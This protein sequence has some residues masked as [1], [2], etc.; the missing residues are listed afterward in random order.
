MADAVGGSFRDPSGCVLRHDGVL[1]RVIRASY[2]AD[3][4]R[5]AETGFIDELQREGQLIPHAAAERSLV[6]APDAWMVIRPETVPFIS[7]PWEWCFG[8]LKAAALLT[9]Q[10][11]RRALDRGFTLKDAGAT[12]IQ[13]IRS[14]P[15]LIDT[16]SFRRYEEGSPWIAY[17]QFCQHFLA[18]LLLMSMVDPR[19]ALIGRSHLDGIPLDLAATLLPARTR[20]RPATA[21][22]IHL[23]ASS[24]RKHADDRKPDPRLAHRVSRTGLLGLIDNLE[25][26][27]RGLDCRLTGGAWWDYEETHA[28][29]DGAREAKDRLVLQLA[30]S[31]PGVVWDLGANSGRYAELVSSAATHVV[32]MDLDH[33]AVERHW[34]RRVQNPRPILP[35]V[36]DLTNPSPSAGWALQERESLATRG[37]AD[38]LLALALVHHLAIGNNIPMPMIVTWLATIGRRVLIE[39]IP[40]EDSQIQR[41]LMAREDIF[42]D[43]HQAAFE[44]AF[45]ERFRMVAREPVAG[46]GRVMYCFEKA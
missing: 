3:W 1:H 5:L 19:L 28:Y 42:P 34:R 36:M 16:L 4:E 24:I 29:S 46:T 22:H 9:L 14:Q 39:W 20:W 33:G 38:T 6:S 17:R 13:F 30:G 15:V 7:Y 10:L 43:Y 26:L 37:P 23:H 21:L 41:L 27:I 8:Q 12:N 11:Q 2:R 18:P 25:T 35:L 31:E 32:A 44:R 45:Q 40:K